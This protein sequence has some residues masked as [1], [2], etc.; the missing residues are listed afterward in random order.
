LQKL[1]DIEGEVLETTD[2]QLMQLYFKLVEFFNE[3]RLLYKEN[4][5]KNQFDVYATGYGIT[6]ERLF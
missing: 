4:V 3:E 6:Y 1:G 2:E 5:T